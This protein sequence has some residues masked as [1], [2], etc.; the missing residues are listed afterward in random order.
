MIIGLE[1]HLIS[2]KLFLSSKSRPRN[3]KGAFDFARPRGRRPPQVFAEGH[4]L[5]KFP[6]VSEATPVLGNAFA[7]PKSGTAS[8]P[9]PPPA[10]SP[11]KHQQAGQP[12]ADAPLLAPGSAQG[13]SHG[14][15]A[16]VIIKM[17]KH[18]YGIGHVHGKHGEHY[19]YRQCKYC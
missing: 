6:R 17:N 15:R 16:H 1:E 14:T 19:C 7:R 11:R 9:S 12:A 2:I 10:P 8:P 13:H 4:L 3:P 18:A 5:E